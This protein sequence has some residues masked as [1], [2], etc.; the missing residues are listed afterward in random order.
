MASTFV[1]IV[2]AAIALI[3]VGVSYRIGSRSSFA[4]ERSAKAAEASRAIAERQLENSMRAQESAWQPYV[5]ADI[6]PRDDGQILALVIGNSGPTVATDVRVVIDPSLESIVPEGVK[7][8][9]RQIDERLSAG[10]GSI[11]P[12]RTFTWSLG[13]A[14]EVFQ[15][16]DGSSVPD[17]T[18]SVFGKGPRGPLETVEYIVALEDL[19]FQGSRATGLALLEPVLRKIADSTERHALAAEAKH[20]GRATARIPHDP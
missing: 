6:R 7:Q 19:R 1:S 18:V 15:G 2:S 11:A 5:W 20:I 3:A 17:L 16:A 10:F 13:I 4:A 12:Q 14:H 9:V 8:R